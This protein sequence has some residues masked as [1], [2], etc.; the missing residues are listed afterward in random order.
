MDKVEREGDREGEDWSTISLEKAR[1]CVGAFV[2][3]QSNVSTAVQ[4][5][6]SRPSIPHHTT[7][8]TLVLGYLG[9]TPHQL[10][11]ATQHR[12]A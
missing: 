12:T 9:Y 11:C 3:Q 1:Q 6:H 10:H 7:V 8:S 5:K 4:R 2:F